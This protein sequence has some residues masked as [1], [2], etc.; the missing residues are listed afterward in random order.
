MRRALKEIA[1]TNFSHIVVAN[2][3][4]RPG[5][6][7]NIP[8]FARRKR[9]E[10][11]VRWIDPSVASILGETY[12]IIVYQEQIMQ[13]AQ[14][15]ARF[16]FAVADLLRRSIS[17]KD[18]ETMEREKRHFV[19]AA[20][21]NGYERAVAEQLFHWIGEFAAYGFPKSHA[22][23]SSLIS[24][25]LAYCKAHYPAHCYAVQLTYA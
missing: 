22:V 1:P 23:A 11:N 7:A 18:H 12:G 6:M 14:T 19:E 5:P 16:S 3:L 20:I 24:Y 4:Y 25:Q 9:G 15:V 13:M 10:E 2:A 17:K 8:T 21:D